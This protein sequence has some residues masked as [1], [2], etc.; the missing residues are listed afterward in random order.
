MGTLKSSS[1]NDHGRIPVL[2]IK[3]DQAELAVPNDLIAEAYESWFYHQV[4][5]LN[6]VQYHGH[7]I[8]KN[9][10]DLHIY[11]EI[12]W[13]VRPTAIIEVGTWRGG[14]ARFFADQLNML[15]GLNPW[16]VVTIDNHDL[17]TQR[18]LQAPMIE[19]DRITCIRGASSDASVV[20]HAAHL[21]SGHRVLV[22]LDGSHKAE[23]VLRD[24][25]VYGGLV[26]PGS[27]LV[28]ED[29]ATT[30]LSW[31]DE[32]GPAAAVAAFLA[33]HH[34]FTNDEACEKFHLTSNRGGWLKREA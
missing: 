17:C 15:H 2:V 18:G 30:P 22:S 10:L 8:S 7:S 19:H 12:L 26:S 27:Y 21:V 33:D 28:V 11:Q 20:E 32:P 13:K 29:T 16:R 3:T 4:N 23:D 25:Q 1:G 31:G 5:W 9:P 6:G 24:M 14:S 34:E